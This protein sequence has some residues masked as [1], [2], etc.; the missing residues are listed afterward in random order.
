MNRYQR[1]WTRYYLLLSAVAVL[2]P[3]LLP[4]AHAV[5]PFAPNH[6]VLV[7][8]GVVALWLIAFARAFVGLVWF[9]CPRC[10][11][12]FRGRLV[13][14]DKLLLAEHN[15]DHREMATRRVQALLGA[16]RPVVNSPQLPAL[17]VRTGR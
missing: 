1:E 11:R 7:M 17:R 2:T 14:I 4:L 5:E 10:G 9:P 16:D 15:P 8:L 12:T 6:R 3:S 13:G